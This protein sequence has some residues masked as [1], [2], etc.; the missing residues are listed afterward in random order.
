M[1]SREIMDRYQFWCSSPI[2]DNEIKKELTDLNEAEIEDRFYCDLEFGTSG[3]RGVLGAGTNRMNLYLVRRLSLSLAQMIKNLGPEEASRGVVIA[4]DPRRYSEKFAE[5]TALV[6]AAAG[7]KAYLFPQLRPTPELSFAVR[8]LGALAGVMITASHNPKEYN[9]YKVYG[10]DGAQIGPEQAEAITEILQTVSWD[11]PVMEAS[12]AEAAGLL[13]YVAPEVDQAYLDCVKNEM[14]EPAL[15]K[16]KG[17]Q[18]KIVFS[19]LH[20]AGRDSVLKV[21][22]DL[23]FTN[24][25]TVKEQELPDTEFSTVGSPNP[26]DAEA[27]YLALEQADGADLLIA[28]DPDADRLGV[29]C[30]KGDG[31]YHHLTGNQT[32]ILL[33]AYILERLK[34]K[35]TLPEDGVLVHNI[36]SSAFVAK[37]AESRGVE[38]RIVDVGFKFIGQQ[39]KEMEAGPGTFLFG[40]EESIGYLKGT[41]TRDKDAVLAAA[42][43]AEAALYY[44]V[45]YG[46]TLY[47]VLCGLFDELGWF[48]DKQV[49]LKF[50]GSAGKEE[51]AKVLAALEKDTRENLA[52]QR[53]A[54]RTSEKKLFT[55]TLENGGFV[56]ARPSG[57]EP[58]LR[59][60]FCIGG[61]T[62]AA[63]S[64]ALVQIEKEL[65]ELIGK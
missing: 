3:M 15:I 61:E 12:E 8:H 24:L 34:A 18:L 32:G 65:K 51:M 22:A 42:L 27:W 21:M 5:E 43:V 11:V 44:K 33:A 60:Y 6:L 17:G 46:K 16:E 40:F 9:G 23:G 47:D 38:L 1:L 35:G 26:E 25:K 59:M 58:K 14:L 37:L 50:E 2:F 63:A 13:E 28:T 57:T 31:S 41:Y 49:S 56:K 7:V 20:G 19:P 36:V 45:T 54:S 62:E 39:I 10:E 64:Q 48:M 30:L 53:V 4:C 29:Q 52:G 55:L